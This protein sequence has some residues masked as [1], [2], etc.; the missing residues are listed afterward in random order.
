MRYESSGLRVPGLFTKQALRWNEVSVRVKETKSKIMQWPLEQKVSKKSLGGR[1]FL[2]E[3]HSSAPFHGTSEHRLH[4]A[5]SVRSLTLT[6]AFGFL[7]PIP[8]PLTRLPSPAT[9]HSTF[10]FLPLLKLSSLRLPQL[11]GPSVLQ[12]ASIAAPP[13]PTLQPPKHPLICSHS[14]M[15]SISRENCT[16][17]GLL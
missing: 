5:D 1:G 6:A 3:H 17:R 4:V 15:L 2:Q 12:P 11:P 8:V 13:P 16:I 10:K 14:G 9:N 7:K